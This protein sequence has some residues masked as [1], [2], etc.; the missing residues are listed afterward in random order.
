[1]RRCGFDGSTAQ[2]GGGEGDKEQGGGE[3]SNEGVGTVRADPAI[4]ICS[5]YAG[6]PG[7]LSK[8]AKRYRDYFFQVCLEEMMP[9]MRIFQCQNGHL[10]CASCRKDNQC[11]K[12]S[13]KVA[14]F[15]TT[16]FSGQF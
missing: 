7:N 12:Y 1:M 13:Q 8:D 9:P 3:G 14:E 15:L 5:C 6:V 10:I 4:S 2:G 16:N 11:F